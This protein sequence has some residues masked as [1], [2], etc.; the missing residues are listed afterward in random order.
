MASG[1]TTRLYVPVGSTFVSTNSPFRPKS[2][3]A[4]TPG[5]DT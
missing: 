5:I 2:A 1:S 3:P 4:N